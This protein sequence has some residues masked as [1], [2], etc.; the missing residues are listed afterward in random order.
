MTERNKKKLGVTL[1]LIAIIFAISET[2]YFGGNLLPESNAETICDGI[3]LAIV[4]VA[5]ILLKQKK[6]LER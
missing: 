2:I 3:V 5:G 1:F 4:I 6:A